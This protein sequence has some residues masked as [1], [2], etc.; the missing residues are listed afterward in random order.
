V[1][2][3]RGRLVVVG[4]HVQPR[5]VDLNRVFWKELE[6]LGARV[7]EPSDFTAAVDLVAAGTI[8]IEAL[9]SEIVP[10]S[11]AA[12]AFSTL[13]SGGRVMKVLVACGG[14]EPS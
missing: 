11:R 14:D 13:A 2:G 9:V 5:P 1:L 12:D 3:A 6:I 10:L 4:I 7:Y 8:P